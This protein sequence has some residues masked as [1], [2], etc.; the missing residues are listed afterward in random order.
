MQH[1]VFSESI[2]PH[3]EHYGI[4]QEN[5]SMASIFPI[6]L[7]NVGQTQTLTVSIQGKVSSQLDTSASGPRIDPSSGICVFKRLESINIKIV[8]IYAHIE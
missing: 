8:L 5:E 3:A 1:L 6:S 4:Q 2:A 7:S